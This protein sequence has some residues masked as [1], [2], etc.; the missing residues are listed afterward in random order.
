MIGDSKNDILNWEFVHVSSKYNTEANDR[1]R[2]IQRDGRVKMADI[3]TFASAAFLINNGG[4]EVV[5]FTTY[6]LSV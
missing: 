1:R 6:F 4:A 2:D 5:W 3:I